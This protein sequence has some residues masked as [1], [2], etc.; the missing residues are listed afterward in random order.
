MDP[1]LHIP[2]LDVTFIS[3][4]KRH[5]VLDHF[6]LSLYRGRCMGLVGE[7]G[8]GK[9]ISSLAIL[10]LLPTNAYVSEQSSIIFR[11]QN[12]LTLSEKQM[13]FI[14]GKSIGMIF[15]DAMSAFNPVLTIGQQ[16]SETICLHLHLSKKQAKQ[17]AIHLL[18]QVGIKEPVRCYHAYPFELSGGMRQRAMIA[19]AISAEP[20][21]II[22][23]EPTTSLDVAIQKQVVELLQKLKNEKKCAV[24]FVGHDLSVVASVADDITVLKKGCIIEQNTTTLFFQSPR[25]AYSRQLLDAVLPNTPRQDAIIKG[26]TVLSVEQLKCYF[27]IRSGILRRV[28]GYVKAV[29]DVSLTIRQGETLALMGESGSGKTTTAKAILQ[30]IKNTGGKIL[31]ENNVLSELSATQLRQLRTDMQI[32]FQDPYSALDPRMLIFDS[33]CEGLL[34][35]RKIRNKREAILIIDT[36]LREVDL[37]EDMKWRYPHEFSGGQRQRLCIARALTLSPQLLILDEPTSALD[38]STQKQILVLLDRLQKEKQLSYLLIT[39]NLPVVAYLAHRVAVM[40]DGKIVRYG[41]TQSVLNA[42]NQEDCGGLHHD[43]Q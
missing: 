10:Q 1:I 21:I 17:R 24:L 11:Q 12:L 27:P 2:Q 23:D 36:L 4:E 42:L 20:E 40:H 31:F 34:I 26:K 19:M 33:L 9:T 37:S 28:T 38:V 22:A 25:D 7:S 8:S 35:Q 15:Q 5:V 3:G 30:L 18:E 16:L 13:R 41:N 43:N 32:I 39:H 29:D 14:R 6:Q